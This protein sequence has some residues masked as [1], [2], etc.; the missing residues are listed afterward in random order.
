M[1]HSGE[2]PF[3]GHYTAVCAL[4]RGAGKYARFDDD[5]KT[6]GKP[7]CFLEERVQMKE[8]YMLLYTR[9]SLESVQDLALLPRSLP[10]AVGEP[11][12]SFLDEHS[13]AAERSAAIA[14]LGGGSRAESCEKGQSGRWVYGRFAGS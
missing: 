6:V 3:E 8:V 5:K 9:T 14:D 13:R 12:Q 2:T 1:F 4:D 11:T 10:Y 7:W